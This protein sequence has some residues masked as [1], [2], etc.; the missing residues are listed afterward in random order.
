MENRFSSRFLS[1]DGWWEESEKASEAPSERLCV[2]VRSYGVARRL[3]VRFFITFHPFAEREKEPRECSTAR[4]SLVVRFQQKRVVRF[5]FLAI[6]IATRWHE[7]WH[8]FN[9]LC[10]DKGKRERKA[11]ICGL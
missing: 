9:L 11:K 1:L 10:F 5:R 8:I 2:R 7:V 6:K 3:S 4:S